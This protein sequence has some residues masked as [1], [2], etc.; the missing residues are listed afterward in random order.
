LQTGTETFLVERA[1]AGTI[2]GQL[3]E[4]RALLDQDRGSNLRIRRVSTAKTAPT[5]SAT[6]NAEDLR[7]VS[8]L[9]PAAVVP[10][11]SR[12]AAVAALVVS[13]AADSAGLA[14]ADSAVAAASAADAVADSVADAAAVKEGAGNPPRRET[15]DHEKH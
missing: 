2:W 14:A 10:S 12:A 7:L 15:T 4:D 3:L 9:N 13:P 8:P 6:S 5:P 11:A 1:A